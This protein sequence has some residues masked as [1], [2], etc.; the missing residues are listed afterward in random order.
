RA[1]HLDTAPLTLSATRIQEPVALEAVPIVAACTPNHQNG[2]SVLI[3]ENLSVELVKPDASSELYR[4]TQEGM[5][6]FKAF[7]QQ[8]QLFEPDEVEGDYDQFLACSR[9]FENS[10]GKGLN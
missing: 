10:N 7:M 4:L 6:S 8:N 2:T 9:R 5:A 3:Y 1:N